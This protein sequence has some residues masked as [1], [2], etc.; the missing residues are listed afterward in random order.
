MI[1]QTLKLIGRFIAV[2]FSGTVVSLTASGLL[3][4]HYFFIRLRNTSGLP[5][6]QQWLVAGLV[7]GLIIGI[8]KSLRIL[9]RSKQAK[10]IKVIVLLTLRL[11]ITASLVTGV[12]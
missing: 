6:L 8:V 4:I 5:S 11:L 2:L 3:D 7:I 9:K 12:F 1:K 10:D